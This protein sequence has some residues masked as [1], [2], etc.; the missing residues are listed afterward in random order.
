[1]SS[2][3]FL[4]FLLPES[5]KWQLVNSKLDLAEKT[6]REA[7]MVLLILPWIKLSQSFKDNLFKYVTLQDNC[8]QVLILIRAGKFQLRPLVLLFA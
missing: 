8:F 5:P 3:S 7:M 1:M 4:A 2:C 6:V